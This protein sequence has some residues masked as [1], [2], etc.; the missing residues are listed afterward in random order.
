M[1]QEHEN[2][3]WR[4]FYDEGGTGA[5]GDGGAAEGAAGG[6]GGEGGSGATGTGA[7]GGEGTPSLPEGAIFLKDWKNE[8]PEAIRGSNDFA[9]V[10]SIGELAS[11]MQSA[12]TLVGVDPTRTFTLPSS[13]TDVDGRRQVLTKLGLHEN[14]DDFKLNLPDGVA[15]D[16]PIVKGFH[17]KAFEIGVLPDQAQGL[18]DWFGGLAKEAADADLKK[19]ETT[20]AE[21]ITALKAE[22][23][24]AHDQNLAAANL[25]I[26]RLGGDDLLSA[27]NEAGMGTHPMLLKALSTVGKLMAEKGVGDLSGEDGM[28]TFDGQKDIPALKAKAHELLGKAINEKNPS[29][30]KRLRDEAQALLTQVSG[31]AMAA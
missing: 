18:F 22:W 16:A 7:G 12:R 8:I 24:P 31:G 13:E 2:G 3:G 21:N 1:K 26:S 27:I 6:T 15:A 10:K 30:Q 29:E 25:A 11:V 9:N 5:S 4:W 23:G 28:A 17:E 14:I 19:A 20:H